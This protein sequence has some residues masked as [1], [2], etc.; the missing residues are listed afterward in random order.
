MESLF[1]TEKID[2]KN[3][4]LFFGHGKNLQR[5]DVVKHSWLLKH[6]EKMRSLFWVP[7][8]ISLTK[9][10]ND[11]Q[12]KL[13]HAER[14]IMSK[15]ISRQIVLD[16]L[17]GRSPLLT[18][19][20]LTNLPEFENALLNWTYFEGAIHSESY[21][22]ILQNAYDNI[23]LEF[24]SILDDE[25]I[26]KHSKT[27]A[28]EY[29]KLYDLVI[30]YQID[31]IVTKELKEAIVLALVSVNI[32]EGIRFYVSFA[33]SFSLAENS[34]MTGSAQILKLIARDENQ[35]LAL[36]QKLINT[37]KKDATEG[38]TEIFADLEA[39]II[40][41]YKTAVEEECE[42]AQYLFQHG[43]VIGL[44]DKILENYVKYLA[45]Q[46]LKAIGYSTLYTEAVNHPIPWIQKWLTESKIEGAPQEIE[47][48]DYAR[49]QI[50]TS[51]EA[52][53]S[54]F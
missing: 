40:D 28:K 30:K 9:D 33:C 12:N 46:R 6:S 41:M 34:L 23:Q 53:Y 2:F 47:N 31:G 7:Q 38:F 13:V 25:L 4:P 50:D 10:R 17:Q 39:T 45:N 49:G 29:N 36:T 35:H 37:L 16:S 43:S 48:T 18:F 51:K 24:D 52:K 22:Y 15:N 19:G 32:I 26:I 14:F 42:W 44:N 20:Q 11:Y 21:T 5:F 3:E 54:F 27:I 8:E 1:T